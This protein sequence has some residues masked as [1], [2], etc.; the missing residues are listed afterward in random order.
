MINLFANTTLTIGPGLTAAGVARQQRVLHV[1]CGRAWI[2]IEGCDQDFWLSAGQSL[3]IA[4]GRLV[5]VEA[6]R[7]GSTLAISRAPAQSNDLRRWL[8]A[9][10]RLVRGQTVACQHAAEAGCSCHQAC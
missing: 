2:T 10:R 9:A 5:V 7:D 3:A 6:D 4:P 8:A 1:G